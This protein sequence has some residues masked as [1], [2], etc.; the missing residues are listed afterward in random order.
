MNRLEQIKKTNDNNNP[1]NLDAIKDVFPR[2]EIIN[3]NLIKKS[4][5]KIKN[6]K[7]LVHINELKDNEEINFFEKM[8]LNKTKTIL[9]D[10]TD[11]QINLKENKV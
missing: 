3:E 2:N 8:D 5:F 10:Q 11:Q 6:I 4:S 9:N 7:K 1:Y